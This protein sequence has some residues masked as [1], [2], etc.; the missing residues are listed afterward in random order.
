LRQTHFARYAHA[1]ESHPASANQCKSCLS[2]AQKGAV[3]AN[4]GILQTR[5][6]LDANRGKENLY[7]ALSTLSPPSPAA[8]QS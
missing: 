8:Y 6:I 7:R 3:D 5:A 2:G 1:F 4:E